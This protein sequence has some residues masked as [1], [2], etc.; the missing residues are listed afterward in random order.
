MQQVHQ[1]SGSQAYQQR[2]SRRA[3][4]PASHGTPSVRAARAGPD[5]SMPHPHPGQTAHAA[6][7]P[8]NH[9]AR[10]INSGRPRRARRPASLGTPQPGPLGPA[11]TTACHIRTLAK[12][13]MQQVRHG[14]HAARHINSG[15]PRRARRPASLGTPQPGPPRAGPDRQHAA[16]APRPNRTCSRYTRQSRSQAYKQ[17]TP[18]RARRPASPGNPAAWVPRSVPK[19]DFLIAGPLHR[20]RQ[21]YA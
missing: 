4:Q 10:H 5:D 1:A 15:R 2:T 3:R 18:R 13:H 11:Q 21:S 16:S 17:R 19:T 6:G 14:H 12:P 9:A 7:P 20:A 8:G